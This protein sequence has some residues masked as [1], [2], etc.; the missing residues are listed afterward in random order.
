MRQNRVYDVSQSCFGV[1]W[2]GLLEGG[3]L[4]G[5]VQMDPERH[6]ESGIEVDRYEALLQMA[7]LMVHHRSMPRTVARTGKAIAASSLL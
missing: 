6:F 1:C 4:E 5:L 3:F 2:E 7:D